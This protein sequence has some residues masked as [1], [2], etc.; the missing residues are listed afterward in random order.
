MN[1]AATSPESTVEA[2]VPR[3][4][5]PSWGYRVLRFADRVLP[6][7]IFR[8]CRAIGTWIA[9]AAMPAQRRNSRE[10]LAAVLERKPR[11]VDVFRHFFAFE[12]SLMLKLRVVNGRPQHCAVAPGCDDLATW[13]A[14]GGPILLGTFHV[15][16]SDLLGFLIGGRRKRRVALIRQ[17]VGN[18]HD[19]DALGQRFGE[20]VRIVWVNEPEEMIFALKETAASG[21]A[22]AL[23]CDRVEFASRTEAFQFLGREW[24]FPFTIYHLALVFE[25]PVLLSVGISTGLNESVSHAS[26][27]FQRNAGESRDAAL[28]RARAHFQA[29]LRQLE[30][31]LRERPYEWFNFRPI[32]RPIPTIRGS[33]A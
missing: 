32:E 11:L 12:E 21:D 13:L 28:D 9:V 1:V 25:R 22:I 5:G 16:V 14:N 26:P 10:Y 4:P 3:N 18:S 7:A 20:W 33:N 15:G 23:Q 17:R 2:G 6:E 19:T 30:V 24:V 27:L 31:V 29:F 8:P